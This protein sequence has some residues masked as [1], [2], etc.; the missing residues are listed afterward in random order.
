[1]NKF[2]ILFTVIFKWKQEDYVAP[3]FLFKY[4][5]LGI[6]IQILNPNYYMG[7][8]VVYFSTRQYI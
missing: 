3:I 4:F 5:L 7:A 8:K 1:M 6:S 2:S